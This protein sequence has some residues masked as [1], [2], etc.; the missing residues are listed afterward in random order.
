MTG[1]AHFFGQR[2][3]AY[4]VDRGNPQSN[5]CSDL[6]WVVLQV[7]SDVWTYLLQPPAGRASLGLHNSDKWRPGAKMGRPT[8]R[9]GQSLHFFLFPFGNNHQFVWRENQ[10]T[11][12]R[13]NTMYSLSFFLATPSSP[14]RTLEGLFEL[15]RRPSR[16]LGLPRA[17][18]PELQRD[19]DTVRC[20]VAG[21]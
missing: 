12:C 10:M 3:K 1:S 16:A 20:F 21:A 18:L 7:T 4:W 8:T 17:L 9:S 14:S 6:E 13:G 15:T 5:S 11:L 19:K 2:I